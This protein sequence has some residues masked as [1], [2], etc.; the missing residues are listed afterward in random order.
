[1]SS[2]II[3]VKNT[4]DEEGSV[5]ADGG[6]SYSDNLNDINDAQ[7]RISGTGETKRGLF[8]IGSEVKIYR[9]GNLGFHG[10][11][12]GISFLDGGGI[13]TDLM[14]HESWLAK[15]NGEYASSPYT[16]TA[17]ATIAGDVIGESNYFTA[18]TVEAGANLDFRLEPTSSLWN[19]LSNLIKRTNQD[20]GIDYANSEV[21]ILDHKGSS[22]SVMT[23]NDGIQMGDMVVRQSYPIGND[24]RVFGKGDGENQAVSDNS[25]YGQDATSKTTY[26]TIRKD[27]IDNSIVSE[28][29]A[30]VL[31]DQL[32][33]KYKDP[34]KVYEFD[35][36]NPN[37]NLVCGDVITLNSSTKGL[38]DEE[39]R[40]V[41]I[42]RGVES[43]R[44]FLTLEVT[45]K[46]Y[47]TK[48]KSISQKIAELEYQARMRDTYMQGTANLSIFS[49]MINAHSSAPLRIKADLPASV[50][51]DEVGNLKVNSF[52][53]DY[54]VDPFRNSVGTAAEFNRSPDVGGSSASVQPG[55]SGSSANTQPG[56]SGSSA[57]TTPGVSGSS[58]NTQP[59]VSG[60][61]GSNQ[62]DVSGG[63]AN[64]SPG[65]GGSSADEDA[66]VSGYS[67]YFDEMDFIDSDINLNV[68]CSN[69][70]WTEVADTGNIGSSAVGVDLFCTVQLNED[71]GGPEDFLVRLEVDGETFFATKVFDFDNNE[72]VKYAVFIPGGANSSYDDIEVDIKPTTGAIDIGC[73]LHIWAIEHRHSDGSYLAVDHDHSS[74]GYS[75]DSHGHLSGS[76]TAANH[77]HSDGSYYANNHLHSDGSYSADSHPHGD[78]SYTSD[79]H[80]HAD[81]SYIADDHPHGDGSYIAASHNHAVVV[82]DE[83]SD[84]GSI[85]A[86]SVDI[87]LDFWNGSAWINKHSVLNTGKT[88]DTEVDISDGGTYPD[89]VG[90]WQVRIYT[91]SVNPDLVQG[92]IKCKHGLD[93]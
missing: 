46:E 32:V 60:T 54:D 34:V 9:N 30:N 27:Y 37:Q 11:V 24:V 52:T 19:A 77:P 81:G 22:S 92:I 61:S 67:A 53:V 55:V 8:E 40:I 73:N 70:S 51:Q 65:V 20:I 78:G 85:N 50:I 75:V 56:V 42:K 10:I 35:V 48:T 63:S 18:G 84:A 16:S 93:T 68:Y 44:E 15:E 38:S 45:N 86:T 2:F 90:F 71:G 3:N 13:A 47:S 66:S 7:L 12:N 82:G 5:I 21:D 83:I 87:Y 76:F 1:M 6:F 29:E 59:G 41:G 25:T 49:E 23:L 28:D 79:N 88:I 26:G 80:P 69:G 17:S 58:S 89:A 39:V 74:G 33:A 62:P 64:T 43:N 91:D 14:G 72:T 36:L 57:S 4:S 31:A